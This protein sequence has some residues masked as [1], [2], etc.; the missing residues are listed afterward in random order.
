MPSIT[1]LTD[2]PSRISPK[3][4]GEVG[5]AVRRA[6][7]KA[8]AWAKLAAPV[9]T[10]FLRNSIKVEQIGDLTSIVSVGAEYGI[11]V[12]MGHH[13]RGGGRYIAGR[14]YFVP[15]IALAEKYLKGELE[16]IFR[17]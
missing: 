5:K 4:R 2:L 8:Q 9:D 1:I 14:P 11:Y 13:T 7:Y 12:E 17:R 16:R 6:A 15:A 10:G 3:L